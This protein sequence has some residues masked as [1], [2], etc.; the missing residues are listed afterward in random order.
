MNG[1]IILNSHVSMSNV[2]FCVSILIELG[3]I[4][5]SF[6]T[7]FICRSKSIRY[8]IAAIILIAAYV[9]IGICIFQALPK[10]TVLNVKLTDSVSWNEFLNRYEVLSIE[11]HIL[12]VVAKTVY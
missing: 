12:T 4:Y 6:F 2:W 1:V 3:V 7:V 11:G 8:R 9:V 5:A 10:L